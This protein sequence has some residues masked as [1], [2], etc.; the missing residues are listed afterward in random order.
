M[1]LKVKLLSP[2][3]GADIPLPAYASDG[4][5]AIDLRAVLDE[6]LTIAPGRREL[7]PTGVAIALPGPD[8]VAL[9]FARSGLA[10]KNGLTLSNAVGVVD[11]D[12][13]GEIKVGLINLSDEAYTIAP[14]DRIA[15]LAVMP[16]CMASLSFVN[17]LDETARGAGGFGS[18]GLQ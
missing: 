7:V 13:R 12:Y 18:T 2:R 10:V 15:Q 9:V 5:A 11:S 3:F 1:E 14:G 17:D 8:Y 4:A 6:P 16:V